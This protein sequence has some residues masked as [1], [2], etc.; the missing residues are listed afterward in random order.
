MNCSPNSLKGYV[1]D[2]IR[3]RVEGLNSLKGYIGIL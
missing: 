1:G 2:Y 3:C